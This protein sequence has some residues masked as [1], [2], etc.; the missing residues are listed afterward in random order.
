MSTNVNRRNGDGSWGFKFAY[1]DEFGQ[2]RW[3]QRFDK[4]WKQKD[5]QK[6]FYEARAKIE[7]GHSLGTA[8]GTV[9]DYL[10]SWHDAYKVSGH[11]K[12]TQISTSECHLN[13]Y[14]IPAIG[15]LQM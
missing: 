15:G 7:A 11:V 10:L 6:A 5:A 2:R 9:G 12:Q 1:R 4:S 3:A 13:A 14:L 8:K